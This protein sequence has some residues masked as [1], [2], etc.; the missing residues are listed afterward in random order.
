[1]GD[2]YD[3]S[4]PFEVINEFELAPVTN[5]PGPAGWRIPNGLMTGLIKEQ[6]DT[7]VEGERYTQFVCVPRTIIER[8]RIRFP[9]TMKIHTIPSDIH[10]QG[11]SVSYSASYLRDGDAV[12]VERRA[13]KNYGKS[14]CGPSEWEE[15]KA[16]QAAIGKD[17]RA[18]FVY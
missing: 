3:L 1:M 10:F 4:K 11:K 14:V 12:K 5:V 13:I 15:L 7:S 8:Y 16:Y 6:L 2:P 17:L 9:A 18:Q